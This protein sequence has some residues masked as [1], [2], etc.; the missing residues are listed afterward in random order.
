MRIERA[1]S[2]GGSGDKVAIKLA[3]WLRAMLGHVTSQQGSSPV[4]L[5][6]CVKLKSQTLPA[7]A[8]LMLSKLVDF[9]GKVVQL[10][11]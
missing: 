2:T 9:L 6:G 10:G 3:A 5:G 1:N 7:R 4:E 8:T 11:T